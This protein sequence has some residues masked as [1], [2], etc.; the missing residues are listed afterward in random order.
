[1]NPPQELL[2]LSHELGEPSRK[3]VIIGEGNTSLRIDEESFWV[4]ASGHQMPNI[5]IDGLAHVRFAP[6]LALFDD[7]PQ[8]NSAQRT[9]LRAALV[10]EA[11]ADPSVET[12]FHAMLLHDCGVGCIAHTHPV[13]VNRLLCSAHAE[14]FAR[15]RIYPDEVVLCGPESVFVPYVDP[16]LPLAIAIRE[17]VHEYMAQYEEA[18]RVILMANHGLITLGHTTTEAL[19]IT[20][21]ADKAAAILWGALQLGDVPFMS[22][23][24]V[25]HIY[26]RPDEIYRRQL[27][28]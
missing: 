16:G 24:D 20:L 23:E 6:I 11:H 8:T 3:L 10:D 25:M 14:T 1:M 27:F 19:N 26:K 12:T 7:P 15:Q 2:Q 5:T 4:K 13:A 28:R 21:M 18:P 22:R 9:A 17:R